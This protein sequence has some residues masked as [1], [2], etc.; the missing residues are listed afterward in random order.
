MWGETEG[1]RDLRGIVRGVGSTGEG[2]GREANRGHV[3]GETRGR[4]NH[5]QIRRLRKIK[6]KREEWE[7]FEIKRDKEDRN[8]G[9]ER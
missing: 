3:S 7:R 5:R 6:E 8:K 4:Y 9:K 1:N 2:E